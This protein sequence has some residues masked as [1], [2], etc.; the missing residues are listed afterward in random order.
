MFVPVTKVHLEMMFGFKKLKG[1]GLRLS[2]QINRAEARK[3]EEFLQISKA[4]MRSGGP[5]DF[6]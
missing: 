6:A 5:K 1:N 3:S 4:C 2:A